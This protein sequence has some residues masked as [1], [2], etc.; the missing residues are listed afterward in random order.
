MTTLKK[1]VHILL[2]EDDDDDFFLTQKAFQELN[3]A[4][5]ITRV[6]NGK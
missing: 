1:P 4:N 2:A 3:L 5:N 6:K